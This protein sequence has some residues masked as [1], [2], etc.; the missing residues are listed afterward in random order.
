MKKNLF[1]WQITGFVFTCILGTLLHFLYDWTNGNILAALVSGVNEST[2]EH[3]KLMFYPTAIFSIIQYKFIGSDYPNFWST[4]L[5]GLFLSLVLIPVFYYTYT[6]ILGVNADWFNISIFFI[7]AAIGY[8]TEYRLFQSKKGFD[9]NTKTA[10]IILAAI[11]LLFT[12][13]TFSPPEIPL[14][15][16]PI[17]KLYGI[18]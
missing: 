4:K 16:D 9:V 12:A 2:W 17:T 8:F 3:I 5:T 7:C 1:V 10:F 13:N 15:Q 14:F 11:S 18:N 6:G